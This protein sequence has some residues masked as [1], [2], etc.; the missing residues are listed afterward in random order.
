MLEN[1]EFQFAVPVS[2]M[3]MWLFFLVIRKNV[4]YPHETASF[5]VLCKN[6]I[7]PISFKENE[8][9]SKL[10]FLDGLIWD[11]LRYFFFAD[12]TRSLHFFN[13]KQLLSERQFTWK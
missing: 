4:M 9:T 13:I 2:E 5:G 1:L 10:G 12:I 7:D 6:W 8:K 11:N 3:C